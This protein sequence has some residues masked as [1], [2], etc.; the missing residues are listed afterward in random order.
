MKDSK[1]SHD[2]AGQSNVVQKSHKHDVNLQKNSSLY[3]Q[4]GLILCLLATYAI[5]EMKFEN[6]SDYVAE[7]VNLEEDHTYQMENF[8]VEPDAPKQKKVKK[9]K[10]TV[11]VNDPKVVDD[12]T[13]I[14]DTPDILTTLDSKPSSVIDPN[15]LGEEDDIIDEDD[16]IE[17]FNMVNVE[18]V[19][20]Y[21]G[22]EKMTTNQERVKCM[23]KKLSKLVQRRFDTDIAAEYGLSGR[24][25]INVQFKINELGQ[26]TEIQTRAPHP[27]LEKEAAR[28]ANKIPE[29]KP[30]LQ[31]KKPVSVLYNLPIVFDV[32][33]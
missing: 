2:I 29:M 9:Q 16:D 21:P 33:H 12:D 20:I 19:P 17:I 6:D 18:I 30:G 22:C 26:V 28:I 1:K 32:K 5:F 23:S 31:R 15:A 4:V 13:K 7:L 3:F 27:K 8:V 10:P 11:I 25:R 14:D 24:Q